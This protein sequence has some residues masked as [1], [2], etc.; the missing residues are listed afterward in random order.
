MHLLRDK[1]FLLVWIICLAF[2]ILYITESMQIMSGVPFYDFDEAHRAENAK[3][4]QEYS[5]FFVPLTGSNF[6]RVL[7]LRIPFKDNPDIFLYYHLERPTFIYWLMIGSTRFLGQNELAYRLPSF[8]LG[9]SVIIILIFFASKIKPTKDYFALVFAFLSLVTSGSLW[10][11]SQYAQL[12]TGL[13][14][15]LFL[16]ILLLILYC[17][18]RNH[19][20]LLFAGISWALAVL[21]KGQPAVI[22]IFPL[23]Y[24]IISKKLKLLELVK[25]FAFSGIV[26][27][28]WVTVL[29][30]HFGFVN[31]I[32]IFSGF[33]ISSAITEYL[34]HQAPFFWY[35]RWWFDSYKPGCVLFFAL[36]I[37]DLYHHRL[38][39]KKLTFLS[40]IFGSLLILSYPKN[41]IWWYVLPLLP[42]ISFYTYL[43]IS[44]Y[45]KNNS[46]KIFNLS[47]IIILASLPIF[48]GVSN[49]KAMIY[50]CL[51]VAV[52][53]LIL[54][55]HISEKVSK[56]YPHLFLVALVFVLSMFYLKFPQITPYHWGTKPV[57]Q[58]YSN[59]P[60]KKCLW[61]GDMP[62]ES[63]LFYSNAGEVKSLN[64]ITEISSACTNYLIT[65]RGKKFLEIIGKDLN[66]FKLLYRSNEI[67]LYELH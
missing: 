41:K 47:L 46:S 48:L 22:I 53:I 5:S 58:Y 28:P 64:N 1:N 18:Y 37:S 55:T 6:D 35:I 16:A 12:D 11:S 10:L 50:G 9:M 54:N 60:G 67:K 56:F 40:Y 7:D 59:L 66:R 29:T 3:R 31:V 23:L 51:L 57:A 45:I 24:L 34:H 26:L 27:L 30:L 63:V 38:D 25:F 4:M 2:L 8:V 13:T 33:A 20:I 62:Q 32:K 49:T 39:W 21:C 36:V 19:E 61:T 44:D 17:Q 14:L 15:F 42:A 52:S 43:S 65:P